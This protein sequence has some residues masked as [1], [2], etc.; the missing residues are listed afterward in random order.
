VHHLRLEGP[1]EASHAFGSNLAIATRRRLSLLTLTTA[2][3]PEVSS[4]ADGAETSSAS[5]N[6]P[7]QEP[8]C[9]RDQPNGGRK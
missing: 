4:D 1:I 3:P 6:L 5:V 7:R 2:D 9:S 8:E